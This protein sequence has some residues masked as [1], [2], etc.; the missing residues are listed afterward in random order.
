MTMS[1]LSGKLETESDAVE[2]LGNWLTG[3][4]GGFSLAVDSWFLAKRE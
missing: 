4:D 3:G 1:I 2:C